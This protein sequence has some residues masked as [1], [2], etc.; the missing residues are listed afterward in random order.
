MM[1]AAPAARRRRPNDGRRRRGRDPGAGSARPA[2]STRRWPWARPCRS[3]RSTGCSSWPPGPTTRWA[4]CRRCSPRRQPRRQHARLFDNTDAYF[5]TGLINSALVAGTVTVS[6][7]LFS[8]LAGF[9]F[10]KLRFRGRNALLLVIV[11]TMMVPT[12]LGVIP[13]YMLMTKLDWV[14]T[15]R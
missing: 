3:S 11:A 4:G 14:G 9:A 7:V 13:L 6:V 10:A 2:R 12:Q 8:T 15:Q 5:L 1:L